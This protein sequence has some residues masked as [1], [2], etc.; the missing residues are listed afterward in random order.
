[1]LKHFILWGFVLL[2]TGSC[3]EGGAKIDSPAIASAPLEKATFSGGRL[4]YLEEPFEALD[5]VISV[6][7]GFSRGNEKKP[8]DQ[9]MATRKSSQRYA[10]QITFDPDVISF[11]ELLDIFWQQID[12]TD[13]GGLFSHRGNQYAPAVYYHSA[14]QREVTAAS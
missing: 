7:S 13:R 12:P 4:G 6:Q 9:E 14:R 1:M 2:V 5:G 8:G 10:V 3:S 11:S